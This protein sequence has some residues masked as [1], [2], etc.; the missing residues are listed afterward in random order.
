[1]T[2]STV[3]VRGWECNGCVASS[4]HRWKFLGKLPCSLIRYTAMRSYRE[5]LAVDLTHVRVRA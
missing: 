1:M 2:V 5:K 3:A 4:A